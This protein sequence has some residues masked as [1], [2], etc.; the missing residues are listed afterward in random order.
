R[1]DRDWSSDVCSSD[2]HRARTRTVPI[3]D[4]GFLS[5]GE[6]TALVAPG[7]SVDWLCLPRMDSAS[8]FGAVLDRHAGRFL[9]APDDI[10]VPAGRSEERRVGKECRSRG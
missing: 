3:G 4:Y 7:G 2:L 8:V 9:L 1:S 6:V 5:D 10:S